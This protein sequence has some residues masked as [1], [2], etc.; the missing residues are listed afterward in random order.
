MTLKVDAVVIGAGVV[1][2]ACAR[3]FSEAG[4]ETIILEKENSFGQGISSRNSE[5]IHAGLYYEPGSL[6]ARLCRQGRDWLYEYCDLNAVSYNKIGKWVVANGKQQLDDLAKI[7]ASARRNLCTDVFMISGLEALQL[8]PEIR[9][10]QILVSPST[11]IIDSHS[12][13]MSLLADTERRG[14]QLV[15]NTEVDSFDF[16][17][18]IIKLKINDAQRTE[19]LTKYLV[20]AAGLSAVRLAKKMQNYPI[21]LLPES[22]Y[23]K[24]NY[25][26]L[27]GA[28][29]F[30]RLVYPVPEPG[31]LGVHLTLDL[32]GRGRFGP[33]VEWVNELDYSV[34]YSAKKV[35]IFCKAIREY[36]PGCEAERLQPDYAGIRPKLGV[37]SGFHKDFVIQCPREHG[38]SGLVNL[39]GIESPGLTACLAIAEESLSRLGLAKN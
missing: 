26:S 25:F 2:L 15:T 30:S 4:L 19:L 36:W 21:S 28:A 8:E 9:A 20:N 34:S 10:E 37:P 35:E 13:M 6:K 1:G 32:A 11:G 12:L 27:T 31:G 33:D 29:P 23:A 38:F 39:F 22:R 24:G 3:A 16:S 5:V 7:E 17:A 14:G 18:G